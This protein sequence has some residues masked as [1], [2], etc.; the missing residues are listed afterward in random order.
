MKNI[1]DFKVKPDE[2]IYDAILFAKYHLKN[3]KLVFKT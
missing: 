2:D 1:I 3:F